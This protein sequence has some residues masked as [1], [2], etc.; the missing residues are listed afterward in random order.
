MLF[1]SNFARYT[2]LPEIIKPVAIAIG[3]PGYFKGARELRLAPTR[4]MLQLSHEAYVEA[5]DLLLSK[6]DPK[7][8]VTSLGDNVAMLCWESPGVF[9]H[10]RRVAEWLESALA[11]EVPEF[12]FDRASYP[13][14][15]NMAEKGSVEAKRF[16]RT[17]IKADHT[18]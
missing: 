15:S 7:E 9:C 14:Y 4:E 17:L 13:L 2:R 8:I 3:V 5:F 18:A 10:R 16:P 6:L 1:T 11:I 12:G